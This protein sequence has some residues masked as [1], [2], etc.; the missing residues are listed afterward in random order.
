MKN[1]EKSVATPMTCSEPGVHMVEKRLD[2]SFVALEKD[3]LTDPFRRDQTRALQRRE[4]SRHGGLRQ[5]AAC[6]DLSSAY[7]V[8]QRQFLIG[9]MRVRL[10]QPAKNLPAD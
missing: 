5:T 7:A 1:Q 9:E 8:I 10:P 2:D 3:P 4:M 6:V